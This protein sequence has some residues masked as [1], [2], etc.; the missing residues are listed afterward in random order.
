MIEMDEETRYAFN[1]LNIERLRF[2]QWAESCRETDSEY[3]NPSPRTGKYA[4]QIIRETLEILLIFFGEAATLQR[5][6]DPIRRSGGRKYNADGNRIGL[7]KRITYSLSDRECFSEMTTELSYFND[8]L[9]VLKPTL[10]ARRDIAQALQKRP[11]FFEDA[12]AWDNDGPD[13]FDTGAAG[14]AAQIATTMERSLRKRR[15]Q[16]GISRPHSSGYGD[17]PRFSHSSSRKVPRLDLRYEVESDFEHP[18]HEYK[19]YSPAPSYHSSVSR[20]T[21]TS[22]SSRSSTHS[23]QSN[24]DA[25]REMMGDIMF[26]NGRR[27]STYR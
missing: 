6:Y 22:G 1:K 11:Q 15:H 27:T 12:K 10:Q 2:L 16:Q 14:I 8:R 26:V 9:P 21:R 24:S 17:K 3:V 13:F 5:K 4:D 18:R 20:H 23:R 19:P 7:K 25:F